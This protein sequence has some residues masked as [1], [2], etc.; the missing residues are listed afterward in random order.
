MLDACASELIAEPTFGSTD[1]AAALVG[2][3]EFGQVPDE[4]EV[5]SQKL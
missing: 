4:L 3:L 5:R 1:G 2:A